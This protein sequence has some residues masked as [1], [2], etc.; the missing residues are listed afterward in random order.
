MALF[1]FQF[2]YYQRVYTLAHSLAGKN[3][4]KKEMTGDLLIV[5]YFFF[6]SYIKKKKRINVGA[7]FFSLLNRHCAVHI[8]YPV[9]MW[10]A[11]LN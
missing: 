9:E 6:K 10:G 1:V 5:T 2:S 11:V 3:E 7:V 4:A 8:R